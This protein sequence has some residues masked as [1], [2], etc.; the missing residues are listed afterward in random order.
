[1][2]KRARPHILIG[3]TL[4]VLSASFA[5]AQQAE[6][7]PPRKLPTVEQLRDAL[8]CTVAFPDTTALPLTVALR[9]LED[10]AA[11]QGKTLAIG[12]DARAIEQANEGGES[13]DSTQVI[14][15]KTEHP[16]ALKVALQAILDQYK[17]ADEGGRLTFTVVAGRVLVGARASLWQTALAQPVSIGA[18]AESLGRVLRRLEDL[19]GVNLVLD[20][21]VKD[22]PKVTLMVSEMGLS[23]AVHLLAEMGDLRV[24]RL[25]EGALFLTTA[26]RAER[27]RKQQKEGLFPADRPSPRPAEVG[28]G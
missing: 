20:P 11:H 14:L 18:E 25:P 26:E 17:A 19:T 12:L 9:S 4:V 3:A 10:Q 15:R 27:L 2:L 22:E 16:V 1:M 21:R 6:K 7:A 5:P 13:L 23:T 28:K 24:V 8:N